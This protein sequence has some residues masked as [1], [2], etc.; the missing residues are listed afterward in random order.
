MGGGG[1]HFAIKEYKYLGESQ[2]NLYQEATNLSIPIVAGFTTQTPLGII[3]YEV[4]PIDSVVRS[5]LSGLV[6]T[7]NPFVEKGRGFRNYVGYTF[8]GLQEFHKR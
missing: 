6:Y 2:I 5:D 4:N 8:D 1:K 3:T 7:V